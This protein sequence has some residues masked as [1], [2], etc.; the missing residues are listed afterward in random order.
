M[1]KVPFQ[2]CRNGFIKGFA[3]A[4]LVSLLFY[5]SVGIV[6]VLSM[7][8]GFYGIYAEKK[9]A[10][11]KKQYE[12]TLQFREGLQGIASA[13]SAGYAIENAF[14]E[15]R[16]DLLL[17]YG[18]SSLLAQEFLWIEQQLEMNQSIEKVL[19]EFAHKWNTE[20]ILSFAQVF[21]TA[22]RT[23]GDLISITRAT[24]EKTSMKIEVKRE[25]QTMIAGKKMEG[26]IMNMIPLGMILYFWIC[27]PGFLDCMYVSSGRL[28]MTILMVI[29]VVAYCWSEKI[30][31]ITV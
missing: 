25:I 18:N 20:D 6:V 12:I 16:K 4:A 29:Y 17:L 23:G 11:K 27:S 10:H 8:S 3:K 5:R 9:L 28:V 7:L 30:S 21:Q 22:K 1:K 26:R 2:I 24:A 31:D 15:A 13:L 19:F 14:A